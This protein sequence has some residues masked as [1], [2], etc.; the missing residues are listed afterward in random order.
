MLFKMV[1]IQY[2]N[3]ISVMIVDDSAVVRQTITQ[4]IEA[5]HDIQVAGTAAD[6]IIAMKKLDSVQ[7]DVMIL[8]I[9]MP[10]M[11]GITFLQKIMNENP[12]PIIICSSKTEKGSS[13]VVK[14]LEYGAV[15]IIQKPKMG[16][17][18]FLEESKVLILD[19]IRAAKAAK[20]KKTGNAAPPMKVEKKLSADVIMPKPSAAASIETTEKIVVVGASTGGDGGTERLPRTIPSRCS[21]Y[22]NRTAYAGTLYRGLCKT[23]E[24]SLQDFRERG[25]G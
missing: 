15:E 21:A 20:V 14:A 13:N 23:A 17:K 10:R 6:P 5:S 22:R 24:L 18:Q 8:D 3:K 16:T 19:S 1:I 25:G 7:P 12:L 11:D 2:M 4:L 9:E